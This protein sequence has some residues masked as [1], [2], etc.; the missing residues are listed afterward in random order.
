MQYLKKELKSFILL[1][2]GNVKQGNLEILSSFVSMPSTCTSLPTPTSCWKKLCW[3]FSKVWHL[4]SSL[5][6]N[7][8]Y[9]KVFSWQHFYNFSVN[10]NQH[11]T[12]VKDLKSN[13]FYHWNLH[14]LLPHFQWVSIASTQPPGGA[15][16][17]PG[18]CWP[19][20][21]GKHFGLEGYRCIGHK[22]QWPNPPTKPE[23]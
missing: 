23:R 10:T 16:G 2:P 5:Q 13:H 18:R 3:K 4:K 11:Q 20:T 6:S 14:A 21:W 15:Q 12:P 1:E 7:P 22:Y 9:F 8:K 19:C 17:W